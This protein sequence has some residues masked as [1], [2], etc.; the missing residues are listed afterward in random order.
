MQLCS[1][2]HFLAVA[3]NAART[4]QHIFKSQLR[5][6]PEVFKCVFQPKHLLSS[7]ATCKGARKAV[8]CQSL[9]LTWQ[10]DTLWQNHV[11]CT[12]DFASNPSTPPPSSVAGTHSPQPELLTVNPQW[13]GVSAQE[14][15]CA[16]DPSEQ[17]RHFMISAAP[18]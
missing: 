4:S 5:T 10:K 15:C 11:W 7:C 6:S 9:V 2:Q 12:Q 3:R 1:F 14:D 17:V 16:Q 8:L 13:P 18:Q